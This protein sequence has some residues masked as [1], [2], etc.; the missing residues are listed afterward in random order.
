[1]LEFIKEL[2]PSVDAEWL[3]SALL[4][5]LF[6]TVVVVG[7]FAYLNRFEKKVYFKFWM[8]AWVLYAMW[9][10]ATMRMGNTAPAPWLLMAQRACIGVSALCMFWGNLHMVNR[11][12]SNRE[13]GCGVALIL[14]WSHVAA[15]EV[16]EHLWITWPVFVLLAAASLFSGSLYLRL[17]ASYR[18]ASLLAYGFILWGVHLLG[19]PLQPHLPPLWEALG[20]YMTA[21]LALFIALGMIVLVLEEAQER[22]RALLE[23]FKQGVTKRRELEQE[24]VISEQKYRAL[25]RAAGE[26]IFLVDLETLNLVEANAEAQQLVLGKRDSSEMPESF[27]GVLPELR[28]RRATVIENHRRIMEIIRPSHEFSIRNAEAAEVPCEGSTAM[29]EYNR[30]PTLL[31]TMREISERKQLEQQLLRSEKLSAVG[32]LVAGVAHELNNPLAVIMGYAQIL[33][34]HD[35]PPGRVRAD[36]QKILH[37]S[38]RAAKI[39]HNLLTFARPRDPQLAPVDINRLITTIAENR[40]AEIESAAIVF[41]LHLQP[42]LPQTVADAHQIEQLLTNL[43]TNAFQALAE[44]NGRRSLEVR[45]QCHDA[46]IRITVA[47]TGPGIAPEVVAKIFDPFFTTKGP[48]KGTGLGLSICHSIVQEHH[49]RITVE[50]EVGKG[51]RFHIELPIVECQSMAPATARAAEPPPKESPFGATRYRVLLVDDEPGIVDVLRLLLEEDGYLIES[52]S[53]GATAW[54]MIQT[55]A[56]DLV[57]TDLCMPNFGGEALYEQVRQFSPALARRII[58][59]TGDTVSGSSRTFLESTGNRW[60]GKPFNLDEIQK[61]VHALLGEPSQPAA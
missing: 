8:V 21:A 28:W 53:N 20:Y 48:D 42:D 26:A 18:G 5:A 57:I 14:V 35:Q 39:V 46:N 45:T 36:L 27:L 13:F 32:Q 12:R 54:E 3:H 7:V 11:S 50:S 47:D 29:V 40:A 16:R 6:S 10:G 2:G 24:A 51:T 1:M 41:H 52:A 31:V 49:G 56:Y 22:H 17:R 59:I 38:E 55:I 44:H 37:E 43:L 34:A 58:F 33:T 30:R 4:L 23:D 25:F 19:F 15:F 60:F 61:A 9:L